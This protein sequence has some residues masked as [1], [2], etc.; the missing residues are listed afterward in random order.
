MGKK[1]EWRRS[2]SVS[3]AGCSV[4]EKSTQHSQVCDPED[5]Q[6]FSSISVKVAEV[7]HHA[8]RSPEEALKDQTKSV[9]WIPDELKRVMFCLGTPGFVIRVGGDH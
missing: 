5:C 9:I 7:S 6:M 4:C 1:G 3:E 2:R 8:H